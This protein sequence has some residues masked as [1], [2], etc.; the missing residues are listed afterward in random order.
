MSLVEGL[1][2]L[3]GSDLGELKQLVESLDHIL[4]LVATDV[5]RV[6]YVNQAYERITGYTCEALYQNPRAWTE[7]IYEPD[8][9]FVLERLAQRVAGDIRGRSEMDYRI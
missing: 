1:G 3:A 7:M 8:R 5:S 4:F 9:P 2:R 6:Y